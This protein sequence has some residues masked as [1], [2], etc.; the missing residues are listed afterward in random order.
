MP[1]Q[2]KEQLYENNKSS[3]NERIPKVKAYQKNK[4]RE[5][6]MSWDRQREW[7]IDILVLAKERIQILYVIISAKCVNMSILRNILEPVH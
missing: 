7:H 1:T 4:N 3:K 2:E 5:W 6:G